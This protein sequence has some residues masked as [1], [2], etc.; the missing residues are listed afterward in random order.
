MNFSFTEQDNISKKRSIEICKNIPTS[1]IDNYLEEIIL[2][3]AFYSIIADNGDNIDN[4]IGY[5]AINGGCC[6]SQFYIDSNN[7]KYGTSIFESI[8]SQFPVKYGLVAT[9]DELFMSHAVDQYKSIYKQGFFFEDTSIIIPE[10][11]LYP[12]QL[13]LAAIEDI[14]YIMEISGGFFDD[15]SQRIPRDEIFIFIDDDILLGCG[16][17]IRNKITTGYAS[18]GM[19]VNE[20][21]R[22]RGVGKTIIYRLRRWCHNNNLIPVS[23]CWYYNTSSKRTLESAGMVTK[24]RLLRIN[25]I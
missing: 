23:G 13:E 12:A 22:M 10:A 2:D 19:F 6:L 25:F 3:S 15:L 8:L 17:I 18:I 20:D 7:L 16:I 4:V 9:C 21:Y 11:E 5:F 1:P 24:T 14:A